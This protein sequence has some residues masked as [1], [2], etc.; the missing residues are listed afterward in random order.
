MTNE[1]IAEL[2]KLATGAITECLDYGQSDNPVLGFWKGVKMVVD[3]LKMD[4][5]TPQKYRGQEAEQ[6]MEEFTKISRAA[7]RDPAV[8]GICQGENSM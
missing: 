4:I 8:Y 3:E 7:L 5:N 1:R 6:C 2:D